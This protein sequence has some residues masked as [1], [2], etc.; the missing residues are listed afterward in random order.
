MT[1]NYSFWIIQTVAMMLT[2]FF[3]PKLKV[4]GPI[5]AFLTVLALSFINSHVWDAA[6]FFKVPDTLSSQAALLILTNGLIFWLVVK[7]LPGIETQG[8]LPALVA[9]IVF[10]VTSVLV[11]DLDRSIDWSKVL[12]QTMVIVQQ[13]KSYF[14]GAKP[15]VKSALELLRFV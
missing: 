2:V 8:I 11:R 15:D 3:I 5:P 1:F 4:E 12:S 10:S 13:I 6:L 9:P 14:T 7:I